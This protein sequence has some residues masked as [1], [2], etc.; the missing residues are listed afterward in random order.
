MQTQLA[1]QLQKIRLDGADVADLSSILFS[2]R[3][4]SR[5]NLQ[6]IYSMARNGIMELSRIDGRLS[7]FED[8][9]FGSKLLSTNRFQIT[10][11]ENE[12][13]SELIRDYLYSVSPYLLL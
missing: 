3:D 7:R 4:A 13:I 2:P 8:S 5:I 1:S 12:E 9:L 11:K 10:S 6:S